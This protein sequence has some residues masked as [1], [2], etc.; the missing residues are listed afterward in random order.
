MRKGDREMNY[1]KAVELLRLT[2]PKSLEENARLA[3]GML[4]G[5]P[6]NRPLRYKVAARVVINAAK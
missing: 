4:K 2:T 3:E 6:K 1:S 5:M